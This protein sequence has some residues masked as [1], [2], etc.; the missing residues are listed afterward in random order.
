MKELEL[1]SSRPILSAM[2]ALRIVAPSFA[3]DSVAV[4]TYDA[5]SL[6]FEIADRVNINVSAS[7]RAEGD[8]PARSNIAL[9]DAKRAL[10]SILKHGR[11]REEIAQVLKLSMP[12][13][14]LC[15]MTQGTSYDAHVHWASQMS[16]SLEEVEPWAERVLAT[17]SVATYARVALSPS[18]AGKLSLESKCV[19]ET[20]SQETTTHTHGSR[21]RGSRARGNRTECFERE[22]CDLV[23]ASFNDKPDLPRVTRIFN[24]VVHDLWSD[25]KSLQATHTHVAE[26]RCLSDI[27]TAWLDSAQH[28]GLSERSRAAMEEAI[29]DEWTKTPTYLAL[30][31][32]DKF[33]SQ[34]DY[35][36]DWLTNAVLILYEKCSGYAVKDERMPQEEPMS[37]GARAALSMMGRLRK[38]RDILVMSKIV[39]SSSYAKEKLSTLTLH[40]LRV[41]LSS[42][43]MGKVITE[44]YS[45]NMSIAL[46][47]RDVRR[48]IEK[49]IPAFLRR[50]PTVRHSITEHPAMDDVEVV[51]DVRSHDFASIEDV[52]A[53][54]LAE[55]T[56][57]ADSR[58]GA[59]VKQGGVVGQGGLPKLE[60][61]K[62]VATS[63]WICM[64]SL[65]HETTCDLSIPLRILT[66]FAQH[67]HPSFYTDQEVVD[68]L[69]NVST[70]G[71]NDIVR[72]RNRGT[73]DLLMAMTKALKLM[74]PDRCLEFTH[75]V[76][77]QLVTHTCGK[78]TCDIAPSATSSML[79]QLRYQC[80]FV[81]VLDRLYIPC[82]Y[83]MSPPASQ[84]LSILDSTVWP[85]F[86]KAKTILVQEKVVS[87]CVTNA[88]TTFDVS[89]HQLACVIS[90]V[91][92]CL[93]HVSKTAL[94]TAR[95]SKEN[96]KS[97]SVLLT[98]QLKD[99]VECVQKIGVFFSSTSPDTLIRSGRID[100]HIASIQARLIEALLVALT[101]F[102][103]TPAKFVTQWI[104]STPLFSRTVPFFL[105]R[106]YPSPLKIPGD[107]IRS[108]P[109]HGGDEPGQTLFAF[110]HEGPSSTKRFIVP[111]SFVGAPLTLAP[112]T[113]M[114][115]R[116]SKQERPKVQSLSS[117][118]TYEEAF[119][120]TQLYTA[121]P[122]LSYA[123]DTQDV[124][125]GS[126]P[127]AGTTEGAEKRGED[128][129]IK[130]VESVWLG[131]IGLTWLLMKV[132]RS[133][134]ADVDGLL[135][136]GLRSLP[137]EG[138]SKPIDLSTDVTDLN[139]NSAADLEFYLLC[140]GRRHRD[141]EGVSSRHIRSST[142]ACVSWSVLYVLLSE[143]DALTERIREK[144]QVLKKILQLVARVF[145]QGK[146]NNWLFRDC[147]AA[148]TKWVRATGEGQLVVD[149]VGI[150]FLKTSARVV[151]HVDEFWASRQLRLA[152]DLI[153]A[154][155]AK[156][157]GDIG[158]IDPV[159]KIGLQLL[160]RK[161]KDKIASIFRK[162]GL[163]IITQI[164][165][166][167][168]H[169]EKYSPTR[170]TYP[171]HSVLAL[172][173]L[174]T[175]MY[176]LAIH[177]CRNLC[178]L[179]NTQTRV[180]W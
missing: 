118:A 108:L 17:C 164:W 102:Q 60:T 166:K 24:R 127:A 147:Q 120:R 138:E 67:A 13:I 6:A 26:A 56:A 165:T 16:D 22:L 9:S 142:D 35:F 140:Q 135:D 7:T 153:G 146:R 73:D 53:R 10:R 90:C 131:G 154:C 130:C 152:T 88:E 137:A 100:H 29:Q 51:I 91:T 38:L 42:E 3:L 104:L 170:V 172:S 97:I 141:G 11:P 178:T 40:L 27:I 74:A 149:S 145:S 143:G 2:C 173:E 30:N 78:E 110:N 103:Q 175:H 159:V 129:S 169:T 37:V 107:V 125:V 163:R 109:E 25:R 122:T 95:I 115:E 93:S 119:E 157:A 112:T 52:L 158:D 179:K 121:L 62:Q 33:S 117:L 101:Q 89:L 59:S 133:H 20:H 148:V 48:V 47:L 171:P 61:R 41:S 128:D 84:C 5:A 155:M 150:D 19:C 50:G 77:S 15:D 65:L 126:T 34:H 116:K 105:S 46:S 57:L 1:G 94:E 71:E 58:E 123:Y 64:C 106:I 85:Q 14:S 92:M 70:T 83:A 44:D 99:T 98:K 144:P 114:G 76:I 75:Q 63:L 21:S 132:W 176:A 160:Q 156:L 39:W 55:L 43:K 180:Q 139:W 124:A 23:E 4:S 72:P 87:N 168:L 79:D 151:T 12:N 31:F 174:V 69:L 54:R 45:T 28:G 161:G 136:L 18:L 32:L 113:E 162:S 8:V 167:I 81:C 96:S 49:L 111:P 80:P 134:K 177:T 36:P 66:L 86:L 82:L 68:H